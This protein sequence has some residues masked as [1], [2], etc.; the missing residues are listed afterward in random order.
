MKLLLMLSLIFIFQSAWAAENPAD[1]CSGNSECTEK[2]QEISLGYKNGNG[3]FKKEDLIRFSGSCYHLS[4]LYDK[5]HEH[6]S[7]FIFEKNGRD[8]MAD[9]IFTFFYEED[10]FSKMSSLELKNWF[11]NN[12]SKMVKTIKKFNHVELQF[13]GPGSDYHYWFR[14]NQNN[15]KLYLIGK[16]LGENYLGLVFCEMNPR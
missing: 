15:S 11:I 10:P 12:K 7:A 4:Y 16:Q 5:N 13:L 3:Q 9:G 1:F 6:H 2:M 8:L 14:N